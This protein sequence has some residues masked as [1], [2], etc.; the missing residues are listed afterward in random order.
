M[1]VID[2][3]GSIVLVNAQT[4]R[5]FGYGRE[6]LLGRA[7]ELLVPEDRHA[8]HR[9]HRA[10]YLGEPHVR[11]MGSGLDLRARRKDGSEFPV[12]IS[13]SPLETDEGTF[14]LAAV[15]DVT[16]KRRQERMFRG[17]LEA[18]PDAMVIVDERGSIV[19]VNAQVEAQFGYARSELVGQPVEV[20]VPA[21]Y[22]DVHHAFREGYVRGPRAR[23]MGSGLDLR[24]RRK[25]GSEFPVEISLAPLE[26]EQ[27]SFV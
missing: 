13:L 5:L 21:A 15:R 3:A 12:E 4:E 9:R 8:D 25:D 6:E 11:A 17:L 1:V 7:V 19:L 26:T 24:A 2:T 22:G 20:L 14:V 18:A 16:D 23:P 27:S 10:G